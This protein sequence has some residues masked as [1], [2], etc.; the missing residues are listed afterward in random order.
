MLIL[1]NIKT[2]LISYRLS[3]TKISLC[4]NLAIIHIFIIFLTDI[5]QACIHLQNNLYL[6]KEYLIIRY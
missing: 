2:A 6:N 1:I 5:V 4:T 3:L